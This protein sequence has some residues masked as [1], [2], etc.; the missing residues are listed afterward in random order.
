MKNEQQ[1][2]VDF[3]IEKIIQRENS[4][5]TIKDFELAE[6]M[7]S[8]RQ[9]GLLQPIGLKA[10]KD[11]KAEIV[12]GNRRFCAAKKLGWETISS[13][14]VDAANEEDFLLKNATENLVRVNV[15]LSEQGRIFHKLTKLG[16]TT[17]EIAA[18]LGV[19][20][21]TVTTGLQCFRKIPKKYLSKVVTG[22]GSS[23]APKKGNISMALAKRIVNTVE[24]YDLPKE[25][26]EKIWDFAA[27]DNVSADTI[28]A[29]A[30]LMGQGFKADEALSKSQNYKTIQLVVVIEQDEISRIEK[31]FQCGISQFLY[32]VI[33]NDG[34]I[35]LI[36]AG[37]LS[38]A[39]NKRV[40]G[41]ITRK[42]EKSE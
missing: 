22:A 25:E 2:I 42:K 36:K 29:V 11:G 32:D 12:F 19:S 26:V 1:Q 39:R 16:L 8:M 33:K 31:K 28:S 14:F 17:S 13:V 27:Q 35:K 41:V 30:K 37:R 40:G 38:D 21:K 18:R 24:D 23:N 4:R 6:L 15:P 34:R 9:S 5:G 3:S 20:Q 10:L 7:V